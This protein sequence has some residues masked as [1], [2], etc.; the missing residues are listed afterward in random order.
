MPELPD[1]QVFT[2]NLNKSFAGKVLKKVRVPVTKKLNVSEAA[3]R[4]AIEGTTLSGVRREG[5]ELVFKF[6]NGNE[7]ALH[8]MLKGRLVFFGKKNE[9]SH[10]II[11]LAFDN[12]NGLALSDP[13]RQAK[14]T[15]NPEVDKTPDALSRAASASY[16]RK[17]LAD[18]KDTIKTFLLDQDQIRGI[19]NAYSD[20]ILWDAGISP[21]SIGM[22]IPAAKLQALAK[23]I[24]KVLRDAEK[25]IRKIN[26]EIIGGEERSFLKIHNPHKKQS[27][28]GEK[29]LTKE[30]RG[31]KTYYTASQK[32]FD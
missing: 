23:S 13:L 7:L 17:S 14:P 24:K 31:R 9:A 11:E 2:Q 10:T 5:K 12:E 32:L 19:G 16:L 30:L 18:W 15:L 3:L 21:F 27:P 22:K 20:E 29:I 28:D 4:K 1:L 6:D 8:M 25:Q 26:P